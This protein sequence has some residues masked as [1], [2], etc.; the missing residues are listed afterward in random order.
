MP[1]I[2]GVHY[3]D[4]PFTVLVFLSEDCDFCRRSVEFHRALLDSFHQR[5][6]GSSARIQSGVVSTDSVELLRAYLKE[7]RLQ[8]QLVIAD[9]RIVEGVPGVPTVVL[10]NDAGTVIDRWVGLLND[11]QQQNVFTMVNLA[12]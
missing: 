10:V 2:E 6:A 5:K 8:P 9:H 12:S 3:A 11:Q 7:H 1:A 4:A